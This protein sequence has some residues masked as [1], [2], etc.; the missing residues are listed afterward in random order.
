VTTIA[1]AQD[2]RV[3]RAAPD[4]AQTDTPAAVL[5]PFAVAPRHSRPPRPAADQFELTEL[6]RLALIEDAR[7][8]GI[9][10]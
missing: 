2:E 4:I 9:D 6:L 10:V 7:R 8:Y 3:A 1:S 5:Q